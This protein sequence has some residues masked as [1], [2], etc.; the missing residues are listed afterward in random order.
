MSLV[1]D[2]ITAGGTLAVTIGSGLQAWNELKL[3]RAVLDR[4]GI[5]GLLGPT[6]TLRTRCSMSN[7]QYFPPGFFFR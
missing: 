3:Y 7:G 5:T 1:T 4:L 2:W 6:K